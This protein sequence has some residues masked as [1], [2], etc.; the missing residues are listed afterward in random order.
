MVVTPKAAIYARISDDREGEG[1][2]VERQEQDCRELAAQLGF[3]VVAVY[4]DNDIGASERTAKAKV[5]VQYQAMLE[6]ARAGGFRYIVAYSNSR[7]TRRVKEYLE[8]IDLYR[9]HKVE[10]RTKVSGDHNLATADGRAVA[11]TLATW[12]A[13]EA[14]R[15]SERIKRA[16]LQK[17]Y[18]G[19]PGIQHRRAFGF[20]QD[21]KTHRPDEVAHIREAVKAVIAGASVTSIR[22]RWQ[23]AGVLTSEGRA[24][25]GWTPVYR[26][27][28]GWKTAGVRSLN[29]EP[30]Y[31]GDGDMVMGNW[32]PIISLEERAAVMAMLERRTRRGVKEGTWLLSDLLRCGVCGGKLYGQR[33]EPE[34]RSSYAC[35]SGKTSNHLAINA[36]RLDE[37][38]TSEVFEYQT[39]RAF[40][41]IDQPVATQTVW[42]GEEKLAN[43]SARID[44]LMEMFGQGVL[45]G[46]V[47]TPQIQKLEVQRSDLRKDRDLHYAVTSLA[48]A[49]REEMAWTSSRVLSDTQALFDERQI[50]IRSEVELVWVRKA[51]KGAGS[52]SSEAFNERVDI[53][54][55]QP[56]Q[57]IEKLSPEEWAQLRVNADSDPKMVARL[58]DMFTIDDPAD[59]DPDGA[60]P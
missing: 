40:R 33:A 30:L 8:L 25:W 14:E 2:G 55:K 16:N 3:E 4:V 39:A 45:S 19:E 57:E 50:A 20:E 11:L 35:N 15:I 24:D 36:T 21:A 52:R 48:P 9:E 17:A 41:G 23:A 51:T 34:D 29:G 54:W 26:V 7:L 5:R 53:T 46:E 58:W 27:L 47:I 37:L 56:H 38:V 60:T 13:A 59:A 42:A 31:D 12:D 10:I 22:H 6:H 28:S 43:T 1:L 44:E 18:N 49:S 32:E